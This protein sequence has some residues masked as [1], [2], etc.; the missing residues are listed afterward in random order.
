M[1]DAVGAAMGFGAA[2]LGRSCYNCQKV[3]FSSLW[4]SSLLHAAAC[5]T[6][7]ALPCCAVLYR[8]S[9]LCCAVL[10]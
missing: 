3:Y 2:A 5:S 8:G 7:N 10:R 4:C 6:E 1:S 9:L